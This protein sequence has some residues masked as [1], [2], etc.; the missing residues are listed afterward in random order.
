MIAQ[1]FWTAKSNFI[2]LT[3]RSACNTS[4]GAEYDPFK[5]VRKGKRSLRMFKEDSLVDLQQAAAVSE[6]VVGGVTERRC[7][8]LQS[9]AHQVGARGEALRL[10]KA[11][12]DFRRYT[13]VF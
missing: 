10:H 11:T 5:L 9:G 2:V 6:G 8:V 3:W 1:P 13:K 12:T 4:A 7:A